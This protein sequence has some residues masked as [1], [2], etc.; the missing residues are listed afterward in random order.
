MRAENNRIAISCTAVLAFGTI[1]TVAAASLI[2]IDYLGRQEAE[3]RV[4][5]RTGRI[6]RVVIRLSPLFSTSISC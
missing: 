6:S 4:E 1:S 2:A 3:V 5:K